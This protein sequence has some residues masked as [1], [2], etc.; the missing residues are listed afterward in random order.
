MNDINPG[1]YIVCLSIVLK[2]SKFRDII[3]KKISMK[4]TTFKFCSL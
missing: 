4:V 1:F 2:K 3:R